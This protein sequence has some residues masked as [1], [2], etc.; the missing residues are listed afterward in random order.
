[1]EVLIINQGGTTVQ[2]INCTKDSAEQ[3][4][5]TIDVNELENGN[6]T[7]RAVAKTDIKNFTSSGISIKV[8]K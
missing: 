3:W 6:Y 8:N 1:M 2:T 5:A 4:S 7:L